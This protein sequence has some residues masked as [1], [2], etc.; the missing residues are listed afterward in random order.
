MRYKMYLPDEIEDLKNRFQFFVD[1]D[2]IYVLSKSNKIV[3]AFDHKESVV[4]LDD[5][6]TCMITKAAVSL[7]LQGMLKNYN[8]FDIHNAVMQVYIV[9]E[10]P[11]WENVEKYL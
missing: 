3:K 1:T 9:G 5:K 7:W 2:K 8:L 10:K 4:C 11:T 6:G